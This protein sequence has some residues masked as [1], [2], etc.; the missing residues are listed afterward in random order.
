MNV[1]YTRTHTL[2]KG[3]SD[4]INCLSFSLCGSYLASGADDYR[5]LIWRVRDG[6]LLYEVIFQSAV[7]AVVW[8]PSSEG[9]VVCG[10]RDGLIYR[11]KNFCPVMSQNF[12]VF[13]ADESHN[14]RTASVVKQLTLV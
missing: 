10:C 6:F 9:T 8:N 3:H 13:I 2:V 4:N 7:N 5:L 1:R 14:C 12:V 11:A